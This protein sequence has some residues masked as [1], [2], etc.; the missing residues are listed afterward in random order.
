MKTARRPR[1]ADVS[2]KVHYNQKGEHIEK[3]L[4]EAVVQYIQSE[5]L[6]KGSAVQIADCS[7]IQPGGSQDSEDAVCIQK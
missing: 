4:R 1:N 5:A 7:P 2:V 3:I 6:K